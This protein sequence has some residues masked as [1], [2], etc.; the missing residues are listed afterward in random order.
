MSVHNDR[1]QTWRV[2]IIDD[3]AK[4][5][6]AVRDM[7]HLY[8]CETRT[9]LNLSTAVQEV[10]QWQPHLVILD[11]HMPVDK[12]EPK[13][14]LGA[15]YNLTQRSLAFCEQLTTHPRLHHVVVCVVSVD[16]QV[17]QVQLAEHAGAHRF[18]P[19]DGFGANEFEEMLRLVESANTPSGS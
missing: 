19:K 1:R 10:T 12:W 5:A 11:L 3:R 6:D 14:A 4:F 8:G 7:A 18:W 9:A 16:N 13:P 17:E 2:L 15:K